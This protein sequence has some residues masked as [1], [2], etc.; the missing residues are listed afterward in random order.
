MLGWTER[1][2]CGGWALLCSCQNTRIQ[3]NSGNSLMSLQGAAL[4]DWWTLLL[5][6]LVL[7]VEGCAF[8]GH[9]SI[10]TLSSVHSERGPAAVWST[11][12]HFHHLFSPTCCDTQGLQGEVE[13][14]KTWS[15]DSWIPYPCV[16][17][18]W[19]IIQHLVS[20]C[21]HWATVKWLQTLYSDHLGH[22]VLRSLHLENDGSN[23]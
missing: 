19:R 5:L 16:M 3:A 9:Q 18:D 23:S 10:K 8:L 14:C 13:R 4:L 11:Y 22:S 1:T 15:Q 21:L 17:N 6:L 7:A 12:F 20:R 2:P